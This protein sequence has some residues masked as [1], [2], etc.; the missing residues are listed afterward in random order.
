MN[1]NEIIEVIE[2]VQNINDSMYQGHEH[3]DSIVPLIVITDGNHVQISWNDV[4][5]W[6]S[7]E[8]ERE[9][10]EEIREDKVNEDLSRTFTS[11]PA[12]YE[13]LEEYLRKQVNKIVETISK[14]KL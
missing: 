14:I 12:H 10:I 8:D 9:W 7:E 5:L 3:Y 6:N 4:M 11:R 13:P 1:N 2:S